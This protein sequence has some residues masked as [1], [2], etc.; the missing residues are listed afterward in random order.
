MSIWTRLSTSF[1]AMMPGESAPSNGPSRTAHMLDKSQV[2]FQKIGSLGEF[3]NSKNVQTNQSWV[4][5]AAKGARWYVRLWAFSLSWS[6]LSRARASHSN[7][8]T[9][10][11]LLFEINIHFPISSRKNS[12]SVFQMPTCSKKQ[13]Q[14]HDVL[15]ATSAPLTVRT[16]QSSRPSSNFGPFALPQRRKFEGSSK[17]ISSNP[18]PLLVFCLFLPWR[19]PAA[20]QL[21]QTRLVRR[22]ISNWPMVKHS[23]KSPAPYIHVIHCHI[24]FTFPIISSLLHNAT[25]CRRAWSWS[26]AIVKRTFSTSADCAKLSTATNGCGYYKHLSNPF[27]N[28]ERTSASNSSSKCFL[29]AAPAVAGWNVSF[30]RLFALP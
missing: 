4:D 14:T 28:C 24:K 7:S 29:A 13:A 26:C 15:S 8:A 22:D 27:K 10:V 20:S 9:K 17:L 6:C 23:N 11:T 1:H 5:R 21:S 3:R 25:Q 12:R 30:L 19:K 2:E 18:T 16:P